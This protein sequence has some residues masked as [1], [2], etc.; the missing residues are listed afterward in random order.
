MKVQCLDSFKD[1][2]KIYS[3]SEPNRRQT[4]QG[5][6]QGT[7]ISPAVTARPDDLFE[8]AEAH[9][10]SHQ[11]LQ[12]SNT[13]YDSSPPVFGGYEQYGNGLDDF[14]TLTFPGSW[15][16]DFSFEPFVD[17]SV[18][19]D[20]PTPSTTG[21]EALP[22]TEPQAFNFE[23]V[24]STGCDMSPATDESLKASHRMNSAIPVSVKR[25]N[26]NE[27]PPGKTKRLKAAK[28]DQW[29]SDHPTDINLTTCDKD[30]DRFFINHYD[31]CIRSGMSLKDGTDWNYHAFIRDYI[32]KC[33][34]ESPFRLAV[35]AWSARHYSEYT[36]SNTSWK[37]YYT[38]AS[39][40]VQDLMEKGACSPQTTLCPAPVSTSTEVIICSALFLC[41]CEVISSDYNTLHRRLRKLRDWISTHADEMYLSAFASKVLML[42]SY[43]HVRN[44]IFSR[45]LKHSSTMLDVVIRLP[46]SVSIFTQSMSYLAEIFGEAYPKEELAQDK[47]LEPVLSMIYEIFCLISSMLQYRSWTLKSSLNEK[48]DKELSSAKEAAINANIRRLSAEFSL[49]IAT[50]PSASVLRAAT[51]S[52]EASSSAV[53]IQP[54]N[55]QI[56]RVGFH[57]LSC[58]AGFLTSKILW[59]RILYPEIRTDASSTSAVKT[60]LSI[61]M[62]MKKTGSRKILRS[63]L[64]PLPLFVAGIETTDDVYADWITN[65]LDE[66]P[67]SWTKKESTTGKEAGK[68]KQPE[69]GGQS[70]GIKGAK[71]VKL[72]EM[73]RQKQNIAARR[74]E[75]EKVIQEISTDSGLF[76][77]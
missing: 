65:Y 35:L 22:R 15:D 53:N 68:A 3:P 71:V 18:T 12:A 48:N 26:L 76:V 2:F 75:V 69:G 64:W 55:V 38:K 46:N 19:S 30:T 61:A 47:E 63:T 58:Y 72:L 39:S 36:T 56:N 11:E 17:C 14:D 62:R 27:N 34:P 52:S 41:R 74:L 51:A 50:Q 4:Q 8:A 1:N 57:W 20:A 24:N 77:F 10:E 13:A 28:P 70:G 21:N 29:I 5:Y 42:L 60:I 66:K 9:H 23:F 6:G 54:E 16:F 25:R 33:D 67:S 32:K 49:A 31:A 43:L 45:A 7:D 73:V 44:S 40:A 59:S 37:F